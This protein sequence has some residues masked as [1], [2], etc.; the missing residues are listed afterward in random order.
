MDIVIR[1]KNNPL[2]DITVFMNGLINDLDKVA[3]TISK[4]DQYTP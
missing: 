1:S 4:L 2:N 3:K